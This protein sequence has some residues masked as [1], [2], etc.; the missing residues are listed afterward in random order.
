MH[1]QRWT[2]L[3]AG[4]FLFGV[5][6]VL[7][8]RSGL[9]LG[10]WDAFHVGLYH[11]TGM[12]VGTATIVVGLVIVV[13]T[14]FIGERPG[15]GTIANMVLIGIFVDLLLPVLP[16]ATSWQVGL[17]YHLAGIGLTGVATGL[18][19]SPGLGRGPRD[20]LMLALAERTGQSV[21]RVRTVIEITV[22]ALGW[23]MGGTVGVGTV[24]FA[25]GIG[26]VTQWSLHWFGIAPGRR[27]GSA[28]PARARAA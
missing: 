19:I 9:G 1:V 4:L 7:M 20:G 17:P 21:Q 12:T 11:L 27:G 10:P 2:R 5:S 18:Y 28:R 15:P 13:G 26:P 3:L 24:L 16:E 14:W 25:L 23:A 6:I 8:I 22:L